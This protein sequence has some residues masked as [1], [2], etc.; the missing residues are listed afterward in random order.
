MRCKQC[1]R[2]HNRKKFCSNK[3]K[4]RY[5]NMHNPRGKCAHF[6]NG[7]QGD[8]IHPIGY[9]HPFASGDEGHGQE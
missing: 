6:A 8:G 4:D 9:G 2:E 1:G 3:C 7:M 5:H